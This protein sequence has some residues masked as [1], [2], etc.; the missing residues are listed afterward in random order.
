MKQKLSEWSQRYRAALQ[1]HLRESSRASLHP[2]RGL[3]HQAVASGLYKLDVAMLHT[4]ALAKLVA[5]H[6]AAGTKE[7][8]FKRAEIFFV[9]VMAP[10]EKTQR[11]AMETRVQLSQLNLTLRQRT[12]ELA[13]AKR[14]LKRE[15]VRRRAAEAALQKDGRQQSRLLEEPRPRQIQLRPL[16]HRIPQPQEIR[17]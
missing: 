9:E 6:Y 15:I 8:M 10:M 7:E 3:G 13:A 1:K 4:Q 16:S 14:K 2:A 5:P 11:I 17:S 12:K